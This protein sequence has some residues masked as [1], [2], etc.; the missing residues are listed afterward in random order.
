MNH[1]IVYL[2]HPTAVILEGKKSHTQCLS[3][4]TQWICF[5]ACVCWC[6]CNCDSIVYSAMDIECLP[7]TVINGVENIHFY[8]SSLC[9]SAS[10]YCTSKST[11]LY[12]MES[13]NENRSMNGEIK[14]K[15]IMC[16]QIKSIWNQ[17][18]MARAMLLFTLH[19]NVFDA[20]TNASF[21][22]RYLDLIA[23]WL[24]LSRSI[25]F[26][27]AWINRAVFAARRNHAARVCDDNCD[28]RM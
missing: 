27:D 25:R 2:A 17:T 5:C 19:E 26:Y 24:Q 11:D 9:N 10:V 8:F 20:C 14:I 4:T 13:W 21:L 22:S 16:A 12:S 28:W 23:E 3:H 7:F 6:Y 18:R 1:F 15:K